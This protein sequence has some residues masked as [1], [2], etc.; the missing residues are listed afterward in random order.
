[1]LRKTKKGKA[2]GPDDI[3]VEVWIAEGT[4]GVKFL[5]QTFSTDSCEERKCQMNGGVCLSRCTKGKCQ[6]V[7]KLLRNQV[8]ES[9]Y[10]TVEESNTFKDKK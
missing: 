10:E 4:K 8:A 3:P 5:L 2:Q 9:Y 7:W 6:R 1:M